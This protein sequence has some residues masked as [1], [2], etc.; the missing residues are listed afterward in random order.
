MKNLKLIKILGIISF[1]LVSVSIIAIIICAILTSKFIYEDLNNPNVVEPNPTTVIAIG[2]F[3]IISI[4]TST[5]GIVISFIAAILILVTDFGN[6]EINDSRVLWGVLSLILL[7]PIG[8]LAFYF[9]NSKKISDP[10]LPEDVYRGDSPKQDDDDSL[11]TIKKAFE[12]FESGVITKEE[13][14]EIK[15]KNLKR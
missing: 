12:M 9:T 1:V 15:K 4:I 10:I 8:V 7:G 5:I 11:E 14:E 3:T 6:K 13:F 2:T